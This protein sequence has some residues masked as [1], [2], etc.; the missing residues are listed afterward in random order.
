MFVQVVIEYQYSLV[1]QACFLTEL[2]CTVWTV[3]K[4]SLASG[5]NMYINYCKQLTEAE[6]CVQCIYGPPNIKIPTYILIYGLMGI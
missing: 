2:K 1:D 6:E 4:D 3:M 5:S